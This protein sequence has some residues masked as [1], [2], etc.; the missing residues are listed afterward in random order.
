LTGLRRSSRSEAFSGEGARLFGG[1]WNSPGVAVVYASESLA[2]AALET[3][4]HADRRRFERGYLAYRL[5]V[6][7]RLIL[8]VEQDTLSPDWRD[9]PV[10][11]GARRLGDGWV[12][13]GAS[14]ALS[15]P[16][17]LVPFERN[18]LL[19]PAH[20]DFGAVHIEEPVEFSF[21]ER[22]A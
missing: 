20:R 1:R 4:A 6:P 10:S 21:D 8:A 11:L 7:E 14:V 9:R 13:E 22:L 16:S 15:V 19:N 18:L 3:L 12:E 17:A 2:L 5:R